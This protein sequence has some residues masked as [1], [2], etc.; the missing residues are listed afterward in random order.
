V[1]QHATTHLDCCPSICTGVFWKIEKW[2]RK[3]RKTHQT[4]HKPRQ[5]DSS[6]KRENSSWDQG[7]INGTR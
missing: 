7:E 4:S 6:P 3:A 5:R 1:F 2:K